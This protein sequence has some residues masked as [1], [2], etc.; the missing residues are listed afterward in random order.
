MGT[1]ALLLTHPLPLSCWDARSLVACST[2]GCNCQD[3]ESEPQVSPS[4]GTVCTGLLAAQDQGHGG[5]FPPH[6]LGI[7]LHYL[8]RHPLHLFLSYLPGG[9]QLTHILEQAFMT[10]VPGLVR[11]L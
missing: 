6:T 1:R 7:F 5:S 8:F 2:E 10:F 4:T 3:E 11:W 9:T